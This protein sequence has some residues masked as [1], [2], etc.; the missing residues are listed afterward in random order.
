MIKAPGKNA[1]EEEGQ[2][3]INLPETNV[4]RATDEQQTINPQE[5]TRSGN[6][7]E[8]PPSP[9]EDEEENENRQND[10]DRQKAMYGAMYGIEASGMEITLSQEG[11]VRSEYGYQPTPTQPE[12]S[13]DEH[14]S[15]KTPP[16][17]QEKEKKEEPTTMEN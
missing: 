8:D 6:N 1:Q 17:K 16:W 3:T 14:N 7:E 9:L 13:D 5:P 11:S 2:Q 12:L 15:Q 4:A 10:D